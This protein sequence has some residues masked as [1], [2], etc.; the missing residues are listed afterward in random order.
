VIGVLNVVS[1][2][3]LDASSSGSF[4]PAVN[5]TVCNTFQIAQADVNGDGHVDV[6]IGTGP[7]LTAQNGVIP[8]A[9]GVLPQLDAPGSLCVLQPLHWTAG[10]PLV[11]DVPRGIPGCRNVWRQA[12]TV[13]SLMGQFFRRNDSMK[14]LTSCLALGA[15]A[16][17][18]M[19]RPDHAEAAVI[20]GVAPPAPIVEIMPRVPAP[21]Y[22]WRPGYWCWGAGRYVWVRGVYIAAPRP[23]AVWVSGRWAARP[24]GWAWVGGHWR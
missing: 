4:T 15:I 18:L 17:C 20:I 11:G 6:V 23:A 12:P 7:P 9:P 10:A 1:V 16:C 8:N 14:A 19:S 13:L 3:L 5:H 22:V 24:G 2:L 21:G